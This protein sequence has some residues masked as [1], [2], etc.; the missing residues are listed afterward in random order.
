[1]KDDKGMLLTTEE[2]KDYGSID[3]V[4]LAR[5]INTSN[6]ICANQ[7]CEG[8]PAV[9]CCREREGQTAA[10]LGCSAKIGFSESRDDPHRKMRERIS[11][12]SLKLVYVH[13]TCCA[14][15][16]YP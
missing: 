15:Q 7:W 13:L 3:K 16:S 6:T 8:G 11:S 2:A 12:D 4:W 5:V 1:M 10:F 14:H 9:A